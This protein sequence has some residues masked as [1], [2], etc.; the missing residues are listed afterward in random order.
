MLKR[1]TNR[2]KL[3][4]DTSDPPDQNKSSNA[5]ANN[6]HQSEQEPRTITV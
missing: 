3:L 5:S 1:P 4:Q 6:G 2:N